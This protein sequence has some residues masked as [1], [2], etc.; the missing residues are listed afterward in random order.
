MSQDSILDREVAMTLRIVQKTSRQRLF[1]TDTGYMGL[2]QES[3]VMGDQV[4][5][6]MGN[7]MP[8]ILRK[9]DTEP[10]THQFLGESYVHGIMDGEYLIGINKEPGL[11]KNLTDK[12]PYKTEDLLLS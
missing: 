12:V 6:L 4:W 10:V 1:F 7:D 9:L 8:C 5:L 2:C 3:C 11:L